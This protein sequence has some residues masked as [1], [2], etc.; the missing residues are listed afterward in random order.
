MFKFSLAS[1]LLISTAAM[2]Q[3]PVGWTGKGALGYVSQSGN[4]DTETLNIG[5]EATNNL[6]VWR[7]TLGLNLLNSSSDDEDT[8]DRFEVYGQ[9]DYKID[10]RAYWL[11]TLRYEDD[12]FSQFKS[13]LTATVGYGR[14]LIKTES[15]VLKG[16]LGLGVRRA[17]ERLSGDSDTEAIVRG[18]LGYAHHFNESTSLSNDFLFEAGSD[19]TFLKNVTAL[20]TE[21]AGNFGLKVAYEIR[22][23]TDVTAPTEKTDRLTSINLVYALD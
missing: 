13:Q 17:E 23:N 22:H 9:I 5:A 8:A 18:V 6:D 15:D 12:E 1:L 2:A 3:D 19:N 10:E 14:T 11:G 21:L 7:Y 20:N 16:E 4:A